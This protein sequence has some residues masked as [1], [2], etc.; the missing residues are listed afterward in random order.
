MTTAQYAHYLTVFRAILQDMDEAFLDKDYDRYQDKR[1]ELSNHIE[2]ITS[3]APKA[4]APLNYPDTHDL[5]NPPSGY[6]G[7]P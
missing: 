3:K 2:G 7:L 6:S 1:R 5:W 4:P